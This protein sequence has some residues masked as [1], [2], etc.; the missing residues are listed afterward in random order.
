MNKFWVYTEVANNETIQKKRQKPL[1]EIIQITKVL[2]NDF[3][4]C[5]SCLRP[6]FNS[7]W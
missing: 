2:S 6:L 5:G 4:L 7:S 1:S 3:F